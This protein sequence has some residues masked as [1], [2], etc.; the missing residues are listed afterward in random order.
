MPNVNISDF[1]ANLLSYLKKAHDGEELTVTS[2]GE[3]LAT[4][5]PPVNK[6]ENAKKTLN[7]LAKTAVIGDIVSPATCEWKAIK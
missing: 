4:I 1:R 2:H 3:V 7:A 6:R 5:L